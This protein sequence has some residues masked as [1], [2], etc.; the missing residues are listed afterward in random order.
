MACARALV[1]WLA[2]SCGHGSA[3]NVWERFASLPYPRDNLFLYD[4]FPPGFMWS[5]GT[6]AYQVEGGWQ[7][8]GR[9]PSIWDT[10][11]HKEGRDTG[12]VASDSYNNPFRDTAALQ[13]LGVSHYRFSISW[14]RLF[15]N[16]TEA[17]ASH[18]GHSY[19]RALIDRL[20]EVGI[21]PVVTLYHWDLPQRLQD[22]YGGWINESMVG[23]FETYAKAC[24]KLFGKDVKYWITIDNP[25]VVAW[26]GYST[27]KLP[28]GIKGEKLL[29]YR[30]GH[31]LIKAHACVWHLY[32]KEFRSTQ[33]GL[34]SI[35]LASHWI[36]PDKDNI[37]EDNIRECRKSLDFVLGWFAKPIFLDGD[38]PLSMKTNLSS[39]LPEFTEKE[40]KLNK[41]TADFFALSF[42]PVLSF[43][44]LDVD[45]MF[46]QME[47][48]NL[49]RLLY[50][51]NV[52]YNKP[53]IF[54]VENGWL[55]AE[56]TKREDAKFMYY[57]KKFVM[58]SLKAIKTDGVNVI[59]YTAWALMDGFE[60]HRGYMIRRGLFYV[61]FRSRNKKLL[62]KSSALFYQQLIRKNG[63]PPQ[64]EYQPIQGT[65]PCNFAW[66][67][68]AC[69]IHIDTMPSQFND[70]SVYIWD[71]YRTKGLT[72][73]EGLKLPKRKIHCADYASIRLQISMLRSTHISHFYFAL[74]WTSVVSK[75]NIS[76]F[77]HTIIHYYRCF[78][79]EL[80]RA[81][82]T[83]V[84]SL[85]QSM[86]EHQGIPFALYKMGGWE[87]FTTVHAFLEYAKLCFKELG[88]FVS[89][90]ITMHEPPVRNLTSRAGH[91][92]LKAH[93][94]V[95]HLYDREFRK[96]QKG[97]I[98]L[99]L[100]A[101]WVEPASPF[102]KNDNN[103][104]ERFLEFEIGRLAE[105]IFLSGD[106]PKVM[107]EWYS[108]RNN[109]DVFDFHLPTFTKEEK[110]MIRGTFDFFA[111]THY[112]TELVHWEVEDLVR[113]DHGLE[114][115]FIMDRTFLQSAHNNAVV[116]WGLRKILNWV[117]SKYGD[118]PI[119][120]LANGIDD[121]HLEDKLRVYYMQHYINEA[122]KATL[123]DGVNLR[124]YFAY[125]FTDKMDPQFG[126]FKYVAN[127]YEAKDSKIL[128]RKIIDNNGFPGIEATP[129]PC[130]EEILECSDCHFFQTR[131]YLLAFVA[132]ICFIFIVSVFMITYY[133]RK[134]KKRYK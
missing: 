114:V 121:G 33:K 40:K 100:H 18:A 36:D 32:N 89:M 91:N 109:H 73:V 110:R 80:V 35:A 46:R 27:G 107:R 87:N 124:G 25:Y 129:V 132:F 14:S 44:L 48:L 131:K 96:S 105:P 43:Q 128:Y 101:D 26:H 120:I 29:G 50:W 81:N 28:P 84:V 45:M 94:L 5:V 67:I 69:R 24:F 72:K 6:A 83:P 39:L 54:I 106:Y 22:L 23:I 19:Y 53:P 117:K 64:A 34:V 41:G 104:S 42:G 55:L 79:S 122:L 37:T 86:A 15:P 17:G 125:A 38:Y 16:G 9:A 2:W 20:K 51:I 13:I 90:W 112:T 133:S 63:F 11:C 92:L 52:E 76:Q 95:W 77:N 68:T 98:S 61:D 8:D 74:E 102:S 3:E 57:L 71:M 88:K 99:A 111:L 62:P 4:T 123:I 49:R 85:W 108:R 7:Q 1:L 82:I 127:K 10:Y 113:Y 56:I 60:W 93:A 31:N 78:L 103:T 12:D 21:E 118:I 66:G 75:E 115:Q 30:A 65:F 130:L 70:P 116:P 47:S 59:G 97:L 58:E 134:G 119:Y 126:L